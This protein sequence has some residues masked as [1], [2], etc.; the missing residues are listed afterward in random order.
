MQVF[1]NAALLVGVLLGLY[2]TSLHGYLLFHSLTEIFS[3][4]ISCGVFMIA[5]NARSLLQ[6]HYLLF[7]G[8]AYLFVGTVDVLHT[9]A[10]KGMGVFEGDGANLPTQLWVIARYMEALSLVVAMAFLHRKLQPV[11]TLLVYG[12]ATGLLLAS[13]FYWNV[14]PDCFR[15]GTGLTPFK[16]YSE[17]AICLI[18]LVAIGLLIRNAKAFDKSVLIL[19]VASI[20]T[21]MARELAFTT[22]LSVYGSS[23]LIGHLL[24]VVS[25]YLMYK[26]IIETSLVSPH[27]LLFRD[28][29]LSEAKFRSIFDTNVV[30][31]V[32]CDLDGRVMDANDGY[33]ELLGFTREELVAG[34]VRWDVVTPPEWRHV[35]EHAI[36]LLRR[37]GVCPPLEKEYVRRN[38]TRVP[39]LIGARLIG[40]ESGQVI[41]FAVE[42][43]ERRRMEEAL[44][45]SEERLRLFIEHA[46]ASLAMFDR[47]MTY[48]SCSRR[49]LSDYGLGERNLTGLSHYEV[50]P[51][52]PERWK[53]VHQR[54]LAGE[55]IWTDNDHFERADGTS[56]WLRWEVRPWRN[57]TGDVAGIVIFTEDI[58]ERKQAEEALIA[59]EARFKLLSKTAA[60]LLTATDPM[61]VIRELAGDVMDHLDC[62]AFFNFVVDESTGK[63][64]LNAFAGISNEEARGL[65]WLDHSVAT[66]G[67]VAR[68]EL[69]IVGDGVCSTPNPWTELATSHGIQAH[70]CHPLMAGGKV[71]GTLAFGTSTRSSFSPPDLDLMKTVTDQVS[72]ALERTRLMGELERSRDELENRVR[73]RTAALAEANT[74]LREIE[75]ALRS[76]EDRLRHNNEL[77]QKVFDG[78][79]DA[80][81][82]LDSK[83]L[84][85]MINK[86]ARAYYGVLEDVD[87]FGKRCFEGLRGR[88]TVCP[89]CDTAF[90]SLGSKT[91]SFER[92]GLF[93][94]AKVESV[95]IY[96]VLGDQGQRDAV[97]IRI[98]DVT[99]A[100]ILERQ[101][102]Q[103]E[104][105]ASLGLVTSGIAHEINNPNSFI[106]FNLP[107]L[108]AYLDELLPIV[109]EY[110]ALHPD[111]EVLHMS[112]G[113]LRE[114][115]FKLITNMVHGSR[116]ISKTI[117]VLKGFVR[118]RDSAGLQRVDLKPLVDKVLALC[119]TELRHKVK[120]FEVQVPEDLPPLVTDPEALEQVLLNLLINA[121]HACDK[122]DSR[123][124][125]KAELDL[126]DRKGY[127]ITVT[128][129]GA[130]I[131][132]SVR[133]RIFDPFFTTK[134]S[135]MGTGLGLYICHSHVTSLGGRIEVESTVGH[136][137]TFRV[138]L[139]RL[140]RTEIGKDRPSRIEHEDGTRE[141]IE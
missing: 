97:I 139:P 55:I 112:Y 111:F 128:D 82:L 61:T 108:K 95:T 23:N 102:L 21:A 81:V 113:E 103:N 115:L 7:I 84:V 121:I 85:S 138:I 40:E 10:Y 46:P 140:D 63:L 96:P 131:E 124:S 74:G 29:K 34:E 99:Q 135:T 66:C 52:A 11:R 25:S 127:V 79:T 27:R 141:T 76:S 8:I 137:S 109:D 41:A 20:G 78:I 9:L 19:L 75:R 83:G 72:I 104:K 87:V 14:F 2:L 54:G 18:L 22:Y 62:Q 36:Q 45:E 44:R 68:S 126:V 100:K 5:W 106:H 110:A 12:L 70:S 15:E 107:I 64:H 92:P 89:E 43:T 133:S 122:E 132:E 59:S 51:D 93:D 91:I 101:I 73:S 119:A 42:L 35:D 116:R 4:I 50:F 38:G 86:A 13:V 114:D 118:K 98:S 130:G 65:E 134:S 94:E 26:A 47:R 60:R 16:I 136:G 53:K 90:R 32:Y 30:P 17:Y 123:V 120:S 117:E 77:L 49:W 125:F 37:N 58:T 69:G 57:A 1:R 88:K 39:V 31:I 6:S 129:N 71:V 67:C 80:L 3:I 56:Q 105:L 48:I 28:L 24:K 33:L